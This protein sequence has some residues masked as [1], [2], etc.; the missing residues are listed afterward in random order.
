M[1]LSNFSC[2]VKSSPATIPMIRSTFCA[3]SYT[4]L[5]QSAAFPI[6]ILTRIPTEEFCGH[7][8]FAESKTVRRSMRCHLSSLWIHVGKFQMTTEFLREY[9]LYEFHCH[10]LLLTEKADIYQR[11][12]NHPIFIDIVV[13][14]SINRAILWNSDWNSSQKRS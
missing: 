4:F 9:L 8:G 1:N 13:K 5:A 6:E 11:T 10:L 14:N 3:L 7:L 12:R 2:F